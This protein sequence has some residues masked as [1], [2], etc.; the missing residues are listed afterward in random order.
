MFC[1]NT[2]HHVFLRMLS[3]LF[4]CAV[5][6]F[7]AQSLL[8]WIHIIFVYCITEIRITHMMCG[9]EEAVE[10]CFSKNSN[11]HKTF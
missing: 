2:F 9:F 6:Y 3:L 10:R 1:N 4:I 8:N 11:N 7:R 5:K